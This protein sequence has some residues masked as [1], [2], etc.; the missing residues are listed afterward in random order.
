MANK[1]IKILLVIVFSF[2]VSNAYAFRC[3]SGDLIRI[4]DSKITVYRACG[5]PLFKDYYGIEKTSSTRKRLE[6]W[7][8]SSE[9]IPGSFD[10][11][12]IFEGNRVVAVELAE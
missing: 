1:I 8:Y 2:V 9:Q 12:V 6:C 10:R 5:E 3:N 4:G 7:T 11:L